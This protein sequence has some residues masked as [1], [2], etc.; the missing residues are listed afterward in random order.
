MTDS[1][2]LT[3]IQHWSTFER[4]LV[5]STLMTVVVLQILI[6]GEVFGDVGSEFV[7]ATGA[8]YSLLGVMI[9]YLML[10]VFGDWGEVLIA[11]SLRGAV[12]KHRDAARVVVWGGATI[13]MAV[14][15]FNNGNTVE[16]Y[17]ELTRAIRFASGAFVLLLA[18]RAVPRSVWEG[19]Y[20]RVS[21][22]FGTSGDLT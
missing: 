1:R 12:G 5:V 14:V 10:T 4:F 22:R 21:G 8:A 19:V 13:A 7:A 6:V 2:S 11:L 17:P 18:S 3:E 20:K 16:G 15:A 9:I